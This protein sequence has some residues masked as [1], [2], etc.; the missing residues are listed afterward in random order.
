MRPTHS[1]TMTKLKNKKRNLE[2]NEDEQLPIFDKDGGKDAHLDDGDEDQGDLSDSEESVFSGLEESGS[3]SDD[4]EEDEED[5]S[6]GKSSD[7]EEDKT[8]DGDGDDQLSAKEVIK[9]QTDGQNSKEKKKKKKAAGKEGGEECIASVRDSGL[10]ISSQVD[11]YE[12]DTSDEEVRI[13]PSS[14]PMS[15]PQTRTSSSHVRTI[16]IS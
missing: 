5:G 10:Q 1:G 6:E 4:E 3:E 2:E 11:E 13:C 7:I 16:N 14:R 9:P 15:S 12:H 8:A